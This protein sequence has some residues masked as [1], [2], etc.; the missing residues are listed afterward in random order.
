MVEHAETMQPYLSMNCNTQG[1]QAVLV[2]VIKILEMVIPL[3]DH[4]KTTFLNQVEVRG[5]NLYS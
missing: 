5:L 4:P 2:Q 3:M 1:E